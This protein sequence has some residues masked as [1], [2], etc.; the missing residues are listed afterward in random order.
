M[1][2]SDNTRVKFLFEMCV[3]N[4]KSI[5]RR[6]LGIIEKRLNSVL[7]DVLMNGARKLKVLYLSEVTE[8]DI[9]ALDFIQQLR[10]VIYFNDSVPGFDSTELSHIL[11][12]VCVDSLSVM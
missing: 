1:V 11:H 9:V 4:P 7:S 8:L 6:N 10:S 2:R 3:Q 12:F 5:I